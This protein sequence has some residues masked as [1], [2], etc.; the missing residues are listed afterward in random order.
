MRYRQF[1]S[2]GDYQFGT[3]TP[4]LIDSAAAVAQSI[5]TRLS[6]LQGEWFLDSQEG[7]AAT[8]ILG[9][10][11]QVT[12]DL[13]IQERILETQGVLEITEYESLVENRSLTVTATVS[14]IYGLTTITET[15]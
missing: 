8:R 12:K 6:L 11:T 9:T 4:F 3:N 2:T 1:S 5:Q 14:T 15:F 10:Q 7:L 13:E